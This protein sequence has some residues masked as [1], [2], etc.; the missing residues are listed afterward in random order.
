MPDFDKLFIIDCDA[1]N[2]GF[3]V[4]LHQ[5]TGP[6]T[7]FTRPFA[8]LHLKLAAYERERI[9]LVQAMHH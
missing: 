7:F 5:G 6:I 4:V 2:V 3:G 8:T 1:F 9:G